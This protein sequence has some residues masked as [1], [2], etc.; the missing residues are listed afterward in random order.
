MNLV[1]RL[2]GNKQMSYFLVN[3][4]CY[5][6]IHNG[7]VKLMERAF[8]VLKDKYNIVGG[9]LVPTNHTYVE[10]KNGT[11]TTKNRLELCKKIVLDHPWISI[12]TVDS[13]NSGPKYDSY[14][15][16]LDR[17]ERTYKA[18]CIYV[19]GGDRASYTNWFVNYGT[20][21]VINRPGY[22]SI[23]YETKSNMQSYKNIHWD[24]EGTCLDISST[25]LRKKS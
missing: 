17:I 25:D 23:Y 5:D 22:E 16:V 4:G 8:T 19:A 15:G 14:V 6:P 1:K 20:C 2:I 10:N 12:D 9:L 21:I 24:D 7:H 11:S 13:D 18:K 3:T